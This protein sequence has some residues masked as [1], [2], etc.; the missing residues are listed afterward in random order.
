MTTLNIGQ[1]ALT[2]AQIGLDT[3]AHNIANAETNG[4]KK[5]RADFADLVAGS[6]IVFEE[7]EG[8][9]LTGP[10]TGWRLHRVVP[11]SRLPRPPVPPS[12]T[13]EHAAQSPSVL[14]PRE[15]EIAILIARGL[16][17]RQIADTL[18]ISPATVE[19][20]VVNIFGK[21]GFHARSQVAAWAVAKDLD[22][23]ESY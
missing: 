10:A 18:S 2:A 4:F 8:R 16:T 11:D 15:R 1:S 13:D 23:P 17:N 3:T 21:L 6:G 7:L 19:R 5:S 12:V 20:H 22:R 14:S 9:L